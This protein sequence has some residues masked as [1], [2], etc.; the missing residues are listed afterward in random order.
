MRQTNQVTAK[1]ATNNKV[2]VAASFIPAK[3]IGKARHL[4]ISALLFSTAPMAIAGAG[5]WTTSTETPSS[6]NAIAMDPYVPSQIVVSFGGGFART[7]DSGASWEKEV[8]GAAP[9]PGKID[10][11]GRFPSATLARLP[12]NTNIIFSG[13][14]DGYLYRTATNATQPTWPTTDPSGGSP[15]APSPFPSSWDRININNTDLVGAIRALAAHPSLPNLAVSVAGQGIY[16]LTNANAPPKCQISSL[17]STVTTQTDYIFWDTSGAFL[18][19][20]QVKV[21]RIEVDN[22]PPTAYITPDSGVVLSNTD[23]LTTFF[24]SITTPQSPYTKPIASLGGSALTF[25]EPTTLP[26]TTSTTYSFCSPTYPNELSSWTNVTSNIPT[27][28]NANALAYDPNQAA[29]TFL[30]AGLDGKGVYYSPDNGATWLSGTGSDPTNGDPQGVSAILATYNNGT[31]LFAS[32]T[33]TGAG[34]YRGVVTHPTATTASIVWTKL[35]ITLPGQSDPRG[36]SNVRTLAADPI[37]PTKI[38]AGTF[39]YGVYSIDTSITPLGSAPWIDLSNGLYAANPNALYITSLEVDPLNPARLY[40]GTYGGFFTYEQV[41]TPKAS[42]N[43]STTTPLSFSSSLLQ[44]SITLTNSGVVPLTFSG[45]TISGKFTVNTSC[46]PSLAVG[47]SCTLTVQYQPATASDNGSLSIATGDPASPII[48]AL[49]GTSGSSSSTSAP[50]LTLTPATLAQFSTATPLQTVKLSNTGTAP[51]LISDISA[52]GSFVLTSGCPASL[53]PNI[54]CTVLLQYN[55]KTTASESS[56]LVIAS[57]D[58]A[59]PAQVALTGVPDGA[60]SQTGNSVSAS[61]STLSFTGVPVSKMSAVRSVSLSNPTSQAIALNSVLTDNPAFTA[62]WSQCNTTLAANSTCLINVAYTPVDDQAV[63]ASLKIMVGGSSL[64][65]VVL[66]GT[67][68]D[69]TTM[70][71]STYGNSNA[72]TLTG[73]FFFSSREKASSGNLYVM[74]LYNGQW[75]SFDGFGWTLWLTGQPRTYGPTATYASKSLTLFNRIDI[76]Q[77]KGAQF[78]LGYG[79]KI[80]DVTRNQTYTLIYTAP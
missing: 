36:L 70:T 41:S 23:A 49:S 73:N 77:L 78:F 80:S 64:L 66:T 5:T 46:P 42:I 76:S 67:S 53:N 40:A 10:T 71:G 62:D 51:L 19:A 63:T 79:T 55:P 24:K 60:A 16:V 37:T 47:S 34:V 14:S 56:L 30:Y 18:T 54:N 6:I 68:A 57:N 12:T 31:V 15:T 52:T 48:V 22:N 17:T 13:T 33:G 27:G 65:S 43:V 35:P 7:G 4:L 32:T 45:A 8:H 44:Q 25:G 50:I 28:S 61:P 21:T 29:S 2:F 1:A 72:L 38:Y 11:L 20:P 58:P 3:F 69:Q 39:G 26:S 75:Y 9:T 59:S 74:G